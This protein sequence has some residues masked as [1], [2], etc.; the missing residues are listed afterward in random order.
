MAGTVTHFFFANDVMNKLKKEKNISFDSNYLAIFAQSMDPFNFFNIYFPITKKSKNKRDFAGFFHHNKCDMFFDVL[1]K[2]I[3]D[4]G[5]EKNIIVMTFVYGLITHYI[6]DSTIHPYVE[7]NCGIFNKKRKE[8][9]K[10]NAKHHEMETFL[11]I[12]MLNKKGFN[13]KKYKVYSEVFKIRN[14]SNQLQVV[15]DKTFLEVFNY[16][17]FTKDYL[18]SIY[19]MKLSFKYLRH[20]PYGYKILC[21]KFFDVLSPKTI[22]NSKFL[23]YS[24]SYKNPDYYLN[25][26]KNSWLYPYDTNKKYNFSFDELYNVAI[27]KCCNLIYD[28]FLYFEKNKQID[29]SKFN[30]SYSTGLNWKI[31]NKKPKFRF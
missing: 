19:D 15:M 7:Y 13:N 26:S 23:S 1:L 30:L 21:Y 10:Y 27:E 3:K 31:K 8:T 6:L 20:D 29:I 22:L 12:Y 14:F 18:K 2:N 28:V 9:F 4:Y 17:N 24:Y 5:L 16:K 25:N 11:D